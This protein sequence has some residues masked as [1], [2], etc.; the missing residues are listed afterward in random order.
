MVD[1]LE[2][3]KEEQKMDVTNLYR[4]EI[5][6]DRKLGVIR[7]LV[8]VTADGEK[9]ATRKVIYTGEAQIMTQMGAL[10]INFEIE[11]ENLA[12]AVEKY[13]DSA[14]AGVEKTMKELQELRR[15]AASKIVVPGQPGFT[16]PTGGSGLAMP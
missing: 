2:G 16:P 8:P 13:R 3:Q 1:T 6:T 5:Y 12:E 4:E 9:D 11:A 10:P 7:A 15:Q 14:K